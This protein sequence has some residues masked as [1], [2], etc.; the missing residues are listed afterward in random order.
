MDTK[1]SK[2]TA[3]TVALVTSI[4][5][6]GRFLSLIA[7]QLYMAKFGAR[8]DLLNS[9]SYA[10]MLPNTVFTIVGTMLSTVVVPIYSGLLV[11]NKQAESKK[12]LDDIISISLVFIVILIVA[13]FFLTPLLI[14]FSKGG[15]EKQSFD[16]AVFCVRVLLPVMF[17]YGLMYIFQGVLQA[18]SKFLLTAAVS[19]PSS[20]TTILYVIFLGDKFGVTGLLFATLLGLFTQTLILL[21]AVLKTGYRFKPSFN[22]KSEHIKTCKKLA[23]PILLG[24]SSYQI[25]TFYNSTLAASFGVVPII[26]NVQQIVVISILTFVYSLAA[27][28]YPRLSVLWS[29]GNMEGYKKAIYDVTSILLFL[30]I[31]ATAGFIAIRHSLFN[32]LSN[33]GKVTGDDIALSANLLV[34]YAL[35]ILALGFKEVFDKAFYSQKNVKASGYVG[36]LI[37]LLNVV[38]SLSLIKVIGIYAMPVSYTLSASIGVAV[39]FVVLR[40]KIGAFGEGLLAVVIKCGVSAAAM[41]VALEGLN[42]FV[43]QIFGNG[44]IDRVLKLLLPVFVGGGL[45]MGLSALLGVGLSKQLFLAFAERLKLRTKKT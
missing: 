38:F 36:F 2:K 41:L 45:Y 23:A 43:N 8:D 6:F 20:L 26:S 37:M 12:F 39:L 14:S 9:Y 44:L 3:R 25:N 30:L 18:H 29:E 27:L 16:Y 19:V 42:V 34:F 13:G 35:G 33:W 15:A 7:V 24:V 5:L 40:R 4:T 22:L 10:L 17:S 1:D 28:Y 31:P 11:K 21:P 32:L